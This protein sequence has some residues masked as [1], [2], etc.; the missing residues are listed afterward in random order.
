[1]VVTGRRPAH[2]GTFYPAEPDALRELVDRLLGDAANRLPSIRADTVLGVLVP[3]AG[4]AFSG[5]VAAAGW[6]VIGMVRPT[7]IVLVG[8]DHG[9]R[10]WGASVWTDGPWSGPLGGTS[11]D[12]GLAERMVALGPPFV[13]D[14]AVHEDEHSLEVQMPFVAR[15]CPGARIV[16][17]LVGERRSGVA[18][19][20]GSW[21]GRL[22]AGLRADGE[23][24][25]LVASSDLAHYPPATV[26][27]ETGRRVLQP[28][29]RLDGTELV[30][31]E[32][33]IRASGEPGVSCGLCGLGAVRCV[34][35]AVEGAGATHGRMLAE[36]TSADREPADTG[37]TVG[38]AAVAF[39]C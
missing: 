21:L 14:N 19:T 37:R 18:E 2:A 26:A 20:A 12:H 6:S 32:E 39:E 24:V 5:P 8:A 25:V 7:T 33:E 34:L 9:G 29:L 30:R 17:L 27:R 38:Y 3:H 35:A 31:V 10:A 22:V 13:A 1:M 15:A 11:I 36:A 23:R 16:P 28:I 4:L